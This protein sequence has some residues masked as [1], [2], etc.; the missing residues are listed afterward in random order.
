MLPAISHKFLSEHSCYKIIGLGGDMKNNRIVV[1]SAAIIVILAASI[2]I[3]G[4]ISTVDSPAPGSAV[5]DTTSVDGTVADQLSLAFENAAEK[6]GPSIVPIFAEEEV[7]VRSPFAQDPFRDFF[8]DDFFKRFFGNA[9]Q[10]GEQKQTVH[11]LGSGVI[12]SGDG[13]I[14]T[15]NHVVE[16]AQKITVVLENENK[17]PAKVIGA[18]PQSD[19]AVI[20]IEGN[21][22]PTATF[23]DSDKL[24]VGQWVI[25][26]GNPFQLMHTVTAGIISARG[27]SDIGLAEY[28]DFIQTDASI[29]PGNSGGALC[30]LQGRVIGINTAISSPTGA[31]VGIG[32]AIPIKMARGVMDQLINKGKVT[33]GYIGI[34]PQD[35]NEN[36]AKALKLKS[37][38]GALVGDVE[39]GGPAE[40]AGIQR[41]DVITRFDGTAIKNS[42]QLRNLAARAKPGSKVTITLVRDG[43][44]KELS[45]TLAERPVQQQTAR[46][47]PPKPEMNLNKKFG[48]SLQ[49][50][51]PDLARQF[52]YE[53]EKGVVVTGVLSGSL[54]EDAGL[55][56]GDLIKEVNR[57]PV[58]SVADFRREIAKIG[59]GDAA[60]LLVRRG[61]NTFY[62]GLPTSKSELD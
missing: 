41:G 57:E 25:A 10:S 18:D 31:N 34:V 26:L 45:V 20:K 43:A 1:A 59:K 16:G 3:Y 13:Y 35:I 54:A 52:G 48:L 55:Q 38:D 7:V 36:L 61:A 51:T 29:N 46:K 27:R 6:V 50:L 32:F 21:D 56:T 44:E 30:D 9:P 62:I 49:N 2:W 60:A 28:E 23:G 58:S 5:V 11:S 15:N 24:R 4:S 42:T 8:G 19:V 47:E 39:S 40:K 53:K 33:R 17:Y 37:S 12:V 14:L 22:L